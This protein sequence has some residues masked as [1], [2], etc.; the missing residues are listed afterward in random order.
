VLYLCPLKALLNN[1]LPRLAS[2]ASWLGRKAELWQ[3]D[4]P[5]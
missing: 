3:G 2:Y 1:L 5:Q 4:V